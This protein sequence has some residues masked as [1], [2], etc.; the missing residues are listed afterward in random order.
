MR[1]TLEINDKLLDGLMVAE[2]GVTRSEAVE[3]AIMSYL[4][5]KHLGG[6]IG[7][8]GQKQLLDHAQKLRRKGIRGTK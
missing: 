5:K 2:K 8:K 1:V 7:P 4:R 3:R 6:I